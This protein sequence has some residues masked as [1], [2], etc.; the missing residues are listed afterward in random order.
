MFSTVQKVQIYAPVLSAFILLVFYNGTG[1]MST[2]VPFKVSYLT[3]WMNDV[4]RF[5]PVELQDCT[6]FPKVNDTLLNRSH[7]RR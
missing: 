4:V 3:T 6:L 5:Q 1:I 7:G 2:Y